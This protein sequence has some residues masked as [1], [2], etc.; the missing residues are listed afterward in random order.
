MGQSSPPSPSLSLVSMYSVHMLTPACLLRHCLPTVNSHYQV[1]TKEVYSQT[2]RLGVLTQNPAYTS[3]HPERVLM[4]T[5][6]A[7]YDNIQGMKYR[8]T[9]KFGELEN[10]HKIAKFK[11]AKHFAIALCLNHRY[12]SSPNLKLA[13][14]FRRQIFQI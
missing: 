3:K 10:L 14:M 1:R 9:E 11:L 2:T 7:T 8:I 4:D 5:S 13:N 12:R 6:C